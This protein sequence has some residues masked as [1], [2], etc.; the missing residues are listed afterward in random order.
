MQK[1]ILGI[2]FIGVAVVGGIALAQQSEFQAK[3]AEDIK[4]HQPRIVKNCGTTDKLDIR[5]EGKLAGN[6]R[7]TLSGDFS[8]VSALCVHGGLAAIEDACLNNK[9]VASALSKLTDIKCVRGTGALSYK[10]N[11]SHLSIVFDPV[12]KNAV[13]SQRDDLV[14]TLKQDLDK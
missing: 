14:K 6:P 13:A 4:S 2:A 7:E 3:I 10:L 9:V 12:H 1:R 11:G 8:G 5:F